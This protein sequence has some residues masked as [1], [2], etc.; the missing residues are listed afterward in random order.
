VNTI[1]NSVETDKEIGSREEP[2]MM[3]DKYDQ[4]VKLVSK[5]INDGFKNRSRRKKHYI[6]K[7]LFVFE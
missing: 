3:F 6:G 7:S 2:D 5:G 4:W 1:E